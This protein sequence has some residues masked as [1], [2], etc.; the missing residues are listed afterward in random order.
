MVVVKNTG[1]LIK[2]LFPWKARCDGN[3]NTAC[4]TVFLFLAE[5]KQISFISFIVDQKNE[6]IIK[7]IRLQHL[8]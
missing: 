8:I 4:M 3:I 7:L 1:F 2:D 5:R 6:Q